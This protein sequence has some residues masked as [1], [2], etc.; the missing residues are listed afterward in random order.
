MAVSSGPM[1]TNCDARQQHGAAVARHGRLAAVAQHRADAR[2][3]RTEGPGI[4]VGRAL[5]SRVRGPRASADSPIRPAPSKR[6]AVTWVATGHPSHASWSGVSTLP[7][8]PDAPPTPT[9]LEVGELRG[10]LR[11]D[12]RLRRRSAGA[13]RRRGIGDPAG[14]LDA[15]AGRG[16]RGHEHRG[17]ARSQ[18]RRA[19]RRQGLRRG[20]GR[21]RTDGPRSHLRGRVGRRAHRAP[22]ERGRFPRHRAPP[23][24]T[25]WAARAHHA[26]RVH[27]VELRL[28][29]RRA[30]SA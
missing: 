18:A 26:E 6:T 22:V 23:P 1:G 24:R 14:R 21:R 12:P 2:E 15:R 5:A 16:G 25:G 4:E 17:G 8:V 29:P 27:G 9:R 13:R 20:R 30:A 7:A 19:G 3:P 11:A 28:P 10:A